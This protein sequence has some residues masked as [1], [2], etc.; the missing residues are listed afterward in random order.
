MTALPD[1]PAV[2]CTPVVDD[3]VRRFPA[4]DLATLRLLLQTLQRRLGTAAE[5]P[6]DVER[7]QALGHEINNRV[8]ATNLQ[9]DLRRLGDSASFSS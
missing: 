8:T 1:S 2:D 9:R 3:F 6:C 5:Q 7:A 4:H